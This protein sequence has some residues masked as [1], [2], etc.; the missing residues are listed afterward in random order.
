MKQAAIVSTTRSGMTA[1]F[2]RS[3]NRTQ[4]ATSGAHSVKYADERVA[5]QPIGSKIA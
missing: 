4:G 1:S 3:R 5:I 2:H